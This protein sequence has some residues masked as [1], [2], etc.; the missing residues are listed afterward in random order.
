MK[1]TPDTAVIGSGPNGL[2]AA[3]RLAQAGRVVTVYE[4]AATV[5]GGARSAELTLP[6]FLHDPY[7]AVFPIAAASPFFRNL[8]LARYGLAWVEPP[9]PLAHPFDDGSA[10]VLHRSV[11]QTAAGLGPDR[12]AYRQVMQPL[13][14]DAVR[15]IPDLL[16]PPGGQRHPLAVARFAT[17][18]IRST[19]GFACSHFHGDEA[20]ALLGGN[21]AHSFL[22]LEAPLTA[23]FGLFLTLLGHTV[24]WPIARGGAGAISS[25]LASVLESIG[26]SIM[27][28][29][30][31]T[32]I[33]DL[34]P[35]REIIFD[36]DPRQMS[37]IAGR[38]LPARFRSRL[39]R[40][41]FG[42]GAFKIDYALSGA[43][44]WTASE[45][46]Q[47]GT[48]H[49][50]GSLEEIA[51]SESEVNACRHPEH[52]FVIVSQPSLFDATRAPE[53]SHTL[54]AYCHVPAGSNVDMTERVE[55]QIERFAP[56]FR[57][58]IL[59]RHV[60]GP[61][62]LELANPNL[63]GG[64]ING[65]VQDI[66]AYLGWALSRRSAYATPNPAL[67]RCSAA[68]PPGGGVHGMAG[69]HAAEYVLR[70]NQS[71]AHQKRFQRTSV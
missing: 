9:A 37:S 35:A 48:V 64:A 7:A 63:V 58:R 59:A 42:P 46:L 36:T 19:T 57:D 40:H 71:N 4:A 61:R 3:I 17:H 26:G 51:L 60:T 50:G 41:R 21:A 54:W 29:H 24:G 39:A 44:P 68:T 56:G 10:V 27:V 5:G 22:P 15:L 66:R 12:E 45:C 11:E 43:V 6:S 14:E 30:R 34:P 38:H 2:A 69:F 67:F 52:P 62:A 1:E 25:G 32:S 31:V 8:E 53:G 33:D 70:G 49:V 16:A 23:G 55:R 18:A 65:G 13:V 28:N 20:R 47:A